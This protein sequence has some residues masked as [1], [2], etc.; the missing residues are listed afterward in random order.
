MLG[1]G[2]PLLV[3]L[4]MRWVL[5]LNLELAGSVNPAAIILD[6]VCL[7]PTALLL[8]AWHP[9]FGFGGVLMLA[10]QAL[11]TLSHLPGPRGNP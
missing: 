3:H 8:Q 1:C 9:T 11:D 6:N 2:H 4:I 10:Q 7:N 5:P